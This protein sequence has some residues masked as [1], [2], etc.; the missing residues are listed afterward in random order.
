MLDYWDDSAKLVDGKWELIF[1][2]VVPETQGLIAKH[3]NL[4]NPKQIVFASNT[5]ELLFRILSCFPSTSPLTVLSSDSEFHSFSRQMARLR[6][7]KNVRHI[8]Q[9]CLP[10]ANFQERLLESLRTEHVDLLFVSHV[11]FNSGVVMT[12]LEA[13]IDQV[14]D[15]VTVVIDGYHA[16][17][18]LPTDLSRL[19]TRIFYL[20]GGYKYAQG[21]EG[22]CFAVVPENCSLRPCNTG[23]FADFGALE[24][25]VEPGA[26][27]AYAP[28]GMRFA[29]STMDFSPVYRLRSVLRLFEDQGVT[30][31]V[32]HGYVRQLQAAFLQHLGGLEQPWLCQHNLVREE[33]K[34][35]GHFFAF[36]CRDEGQ[37]QR[38]HDHLKANKVI[39]DVRGPRIRFGFALYHDAQEF[40]L[41]CLERFQG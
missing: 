34:D 31:P 20:A 26:V 38:L 5:H 7:L 19:S 14:P 41:S 1:G 35:H 29:G 30:V 24:R 37:A 36:E 10:F 40:N 27:I 33:G 9:P 21:G 28:D 15:T 4:L 11:F 17:M 2:Q 8:I 6:E 16:F 23:W 22:C 3:L 13:F 25:K 18:A 32:I 39:T 12:D